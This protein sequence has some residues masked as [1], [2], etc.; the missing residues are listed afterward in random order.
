MVAGKV[1]EL[2]ANGQHRQIMRGAGGLLRGGP[3]HLFRLAS[4]H[5][6]QPWN[7]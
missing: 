5:P 3:F 2:V 4:D 7:C 6:P 1:W